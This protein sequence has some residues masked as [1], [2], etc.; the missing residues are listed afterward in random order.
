MTGYSTA[1]VAELLDLSPA[2]VR[3][4]VRSG[5]LDPARGPSN[6]YRFSFQDL[7]LLRAAKELREAGVPARRVRDALRDLRRTLPSGRPL[8]A[9]RIAAEGGRV[10][11]REG[12][13]V[14]NPESGQVQFELPAAELAERPGARARR[15]AERTRSAADET[16]AERWFELGCEL[17]PSDPAEAR[18]AYGR[19]LELDPGHADAHL[20]LGFLL[21]EDGRPEA[22][23][24]HYRLALRAEPDHALAAFDLGVALEELG[25]PRE[26][27]DAYRR[28][29]EMEP[30]L[31]DAH[32]NLAGVLEA[33]GDRSGALRH[34]RAY[35]EWTRE[36]GGKE[37]PG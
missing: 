13:T 20:N 18:E 27:A 25:R 22:A 34:L 10:L 7:V 8:T 16:D 1:D 15:P 2:E 11:V 6:A 36:G 28:A 31:A 14:W 26:A 33:L 32:Y 3:R 21:Q 5:L 12:D 19:A 4:F 23:A 9:V 24:E 29:L 37:R 17:E 30:A 35:R